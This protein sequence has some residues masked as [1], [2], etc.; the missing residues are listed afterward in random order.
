MPQR[1]KR[2]PQLPGTVMY[3]AFDDRRTSQHDAVRLDGALKTA[4]DR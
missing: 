2:F 1:T 3:L 4:A